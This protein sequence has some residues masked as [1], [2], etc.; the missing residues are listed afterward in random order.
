MKANRAK[1]KDLTVLLP[2]IELGLDQIFVIE[3]TP[4]RFGGWM[5]IL[6]VALVRRDATHRTALFSLN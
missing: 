6:S 5:P 4:K 1:A 2:T 3:N